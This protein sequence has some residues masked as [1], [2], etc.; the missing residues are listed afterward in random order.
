[1]DTLQTSENIWKRVTELAQHRQQPANCHLE[2]PA[3]SQFSTLQWGSQE[4]LE[5][6]IHQADRP[7]TH[8]MTAAES[9]ER[10][11][12]PAFLCLGVI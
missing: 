9:E 3:T 12:V 8:Q 10:W 1:M 4:E 2:Q 6:S 5:G 7:S 11:S